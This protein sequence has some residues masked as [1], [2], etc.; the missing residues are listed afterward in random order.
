MVWVGL[1]ETQYPVVSSMEYESVESDLVV[2]N[3][4]WRERGH[5]ASDLMQLVNFSISTTC[6]T[7]ILTTCE[8]TVCVV[9]STCIVCRPDHAPQVQ[10]QYCTASSGVHP[11]YLNPQ[12][13]TH[14][15][16]HQQLPSYPK[17]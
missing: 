5:V 7:A 15:S 2:A 13:L 10:I 8:I 1:R 14:S 12:L 16:P 9:L 17:W 3:P 6:P 11:L 4:V